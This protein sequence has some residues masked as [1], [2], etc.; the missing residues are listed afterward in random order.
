MESWSDPAMVTSAVVHLLAM[1]AHAAEWATAAGVTPPASDRVDRLGRIGIAL[2]VVVALTH[3]TGVAL[4]GLAGC[5][6]RVAG[7]A[8]R[9]DVLVQ[10]HRHQP[11]RH[12]AALLREHLTAAGC[13][14][15]PTPL[16][17]DSTRSCSCTCRA[18]TSNAGV[19]SGIEA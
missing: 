13:C 4:R 2:T 11:A 5:A 6:R 1:C 10:P 14:R 7:G 9:G 18:V 16:A 15:G 12:R 8:R 19:L 17:Y 3:L